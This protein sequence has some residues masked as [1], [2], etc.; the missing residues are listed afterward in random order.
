MLHAG[1]LG[2]KAYVRFGIWLVLS[3]LVYVFFG[4]HSASDAQQERVLHERSGRSPG[5]TELWNPHAL[6]LFA[7][8]A[9]TV[10]SRLTWKICT[11][12]GQEGRRRYH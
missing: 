8:S 1:S 6:I 5:Q 10:P 11:C 9:C 2:W 12:T 7:L 4:V 3:L